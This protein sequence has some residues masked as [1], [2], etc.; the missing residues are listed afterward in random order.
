MRIVTW[1]ARHGGGNRAK[2]FAERLAEFSPDVAIISE[3]RNNAS[4][5]KIRR[6]L[7][8]SGL[9]NCSSVV[10][11]AKTNTAWIAAADSFEPERLPGLGDE[12]HRCVRARVRGINVF[13]FYFPQKHEKVPVFD[14]ICSLDPSILNEPSLLI[15]D[16]NTGRHY[17]DESGKTFY[18]ADYFDRLEEIGWIDAWRSRN[19]DASEYSWFSSAGNG[20][21]IDHAFATS[22]LNSR[23][24]SIRYDHTVR[25]Q[26]LSDH[27]AMILDVS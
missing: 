4:G 8:D 20:F 21:R 14:A 2:A 26:G 9:P 19:A 16:F 5:E 7:S 11:A 10:T 27:S 6:I 15:G 25:E 23:I 1:N 13:G 22:A 12:S 17:T 3:Y 24:Q 18:A